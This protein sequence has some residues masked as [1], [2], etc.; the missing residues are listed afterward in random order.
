MFQLI[1]F[2]VL[3]VALNGVLKPGDTSRALKK[4]KTL[5]D[6]KFSKIFTLLYSITE[7]LDLFNKYD[8]DSIL[9]CRIMSV[10]S[11]ARGKGL[12]GELMRR[13]I[14]IAKDNGY[15]VNDIQRN[16]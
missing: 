8:V 6:Q 4:L 13:T 16:I 3:G 12:A 14:Q 2:Q 11:R 7:D 10:D 9:E 5:D 15:K 1:F